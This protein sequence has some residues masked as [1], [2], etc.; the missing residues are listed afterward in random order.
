M[1]SGGKHAA[2]KLN[3][4]RIQLATHAGQDDARLA[5]AVAVGEST[6]Y[7]CERRIVE[8]GLEATLHEQAWP[9]AQHKLSGKE[10]ALL[11]AT[12]CTNPPPDRARWTLELLADT[13]VKPT[14][15]EEL[16]RETAR[17]HLAENDLK[18]WR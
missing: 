14:E 3:R 12:A 4:A 11:I 10:E 8:T 2:R 15:H 13:F 18:P 16:P 17:R 6:V 1:L 7:C 9:G 5:A